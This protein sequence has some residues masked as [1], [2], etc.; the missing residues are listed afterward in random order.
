MFGPR[1]WSALWAVV[2][3][4][5]VGIAPVAAQQGSITGRVIDAETGAPLSGAAVAVVGQDGLQGTNAS[6]AFQ[7]S[8]PDGTYSLVVT[9]IGY[10]TGRLDGVGVSAGETVNV[11]IAL[12][13]RAEVLNP[14]V[15]TA[16]R[17]QEKALDAPA[18][19]SSVSQ[20]EIA[21]IAAPSVAEHVKA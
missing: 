2:A 15:V 7:W 8:V 12:R 10:E 18:S 16:S 21:K 17:R 13:S 19:I 9:L 1:R 6:G 20:A 3:V 5:G 11:E 4:L 14:I